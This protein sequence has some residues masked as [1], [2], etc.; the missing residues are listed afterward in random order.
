MS[1]RNCVSMPCPRFSPWLHRGATAP[2]LTLIGMALA[3]VCAPVAAQP[4]GA[5]GTPA[6]VAAAPAEVLLV[7][8]RYEIS[9]PNPLGADDTEAALKPHL[10]EHR[11]LASLEAAALALEAVIRARGF[12]FHR[13]IVPAQRPQG[14]V[15]RLEVL[16]FSVG[17]VNV[18]GNQHFSSANILRSIPALKAG[19]SPDVVELA[20]QLSLANEHPAKRLTVTMRE[21]ANADALDAE[22]QVRDIKPSQ[23]FVGLVGNTRDQYNVVN[24]NTG[25]SRL[26][27][28]YQNSNLFDRDHVGTLAYTTS[29]EYFDSVQQYA[30]YYSLPLYSLSSQLSAYYVRSD[31]DTGSIPVGGLPFNISGRGTF[32]GARATYTLPRVSDITQLLSVAYDTRAFENTVGAVGVLLPSTPVTTRPLSLRYQARGERPWG[33]ASGHIEYAVNVSGSSEASFALARDGATDS[34]DAWRAGF[35]ANY[36]Y[37]TWV[38]LARARAQYSGDYL[39]PGE[40]FGLGGASSVRGLRE[41]EYAGERGYTLTV[42]GLGPPLVG[43]LRPAVFLDGGHAYLRQG[44]QGLTPISGGQTAASSGVGIRWNWQRQLDVSADLAY[45]LNGLPDAPGI[46]GTPVGHVKLHFSLFYRF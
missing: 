41:R 36:L 2:S 14:G 13:V 22:V 24:E 39:I 4:S 28:G 5:A 26:T 32:Y 6:A 27:L 3:A 43:T 11:S 8:K 7:V 19:D 42:E 46:E 40:Q 30:G 15:V 31:I 33:G 12:D 37:G 29:P 44:P 18:T 34:W 23:F 38:L 35:D 10:G 21:S 1:R 45:V 20:R 17:N 16:R 9:G 25:Y